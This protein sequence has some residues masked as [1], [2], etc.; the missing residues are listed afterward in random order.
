MRSHT[1]SPASLLL[2]TVSLA[3]LIAA[4]G[5]LSGCTGAGASTGDDARIFPPRGSTRFVRGVG[6]GPRQTLVGNRC[7]FLNNDFD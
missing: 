4:G 3:L 7:V 2:P 6:C 5:A 1:P